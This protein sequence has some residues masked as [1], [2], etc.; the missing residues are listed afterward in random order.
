M[1]SVAPTG[2]VLAFQAGPLRRMVPSVLRVRLAS[3]LILVGIVK[4]SR[5]VAFCDT[6]SDPRHSLFAW[7]C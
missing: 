3:S 4:V 2:N 1:G 6:C 5:S 7:L